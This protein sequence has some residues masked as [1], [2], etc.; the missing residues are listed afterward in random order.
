MVAL[1][2]QE[3]RS[4][5]RCPTLLL[6]LIFPYTVAEMVLS[7]EI[8]SL[9]ITWCCWREV[10]PQQEIIPPRVMYTFSLHS[11]VT[12][13]FFS[14]RIQGE[15]ILISSRKEFLRSRC[16]FFTSLFFPYIHW[17]Q[18]M[19]NKALGDQTAK[20]R[21]DPGCL[22]HQVARLARNTCLRLLHEG[23]IN[24]CIWDTV[25]I[26]IFVIAAGITLIHSHCF[27]ILNSRNEIK[28]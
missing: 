16:I 7:T 19:D 3:S 4:M 8:S 24:S 27:K 22:K 6:D 13:W 28:S 1:L 25:Y 14:L 21:D 18:T 23:E 2:S 20:W 5:Q 12:M 15:V 26:Y 11:E 10:T 17:M 9:S